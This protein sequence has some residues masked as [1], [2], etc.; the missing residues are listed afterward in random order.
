MARTVPV[1]EFRRNLSQ[2]LSDVADRR[3]HVLV[4]RHGRPAA[5]LIPVD[6]YE[7]LEET[8]EI[9]SDRDALAAFEAEA[10][11]RRSGYQRRLP[12]RIA[13]QL[14][15]GRHRAR[16]SVRFGNRRSSRTTSFTLVGTS[17]L[18]TVKLRIGSVDAT[19]SAASPAHVRGEVNNIGTAAAPVEAAVALVQLGTNGAER[20][21]AERRLRGR[22]VKPGAATIIEG[23]LGR[24]APGRYRVDVALDGGGD[25]RQ[26][27]STQVLADNGFSTSGRV[28]RF[29]T[30]HPTRTVGLL[31]LLVI[32][33]LLVA[34]LR[35]RRLV[36]L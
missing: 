31:A 5:V 4:S 33:G 12:V 28:G 36:R 35:T 30:D 20:S 7:A 23:H 32:A 8:A 22:A 34:L 10:R 15:A 25:D 16:S 29:F 14:P 26:T 19:G 21:V 2:L 27:G 24:L 3:D 9:L 18:P 11:P 13:K 1:R 6:E 17:E